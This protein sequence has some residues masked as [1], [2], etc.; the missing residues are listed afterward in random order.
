MHKP[1]KRIGLRGRI[2]TATSIALN[3]LFIFG[4]ITLLIILVK[5][6]YLQIFSTKSNKHEV[7]YKDNAAY[8]NYTTIYPL[9]Q[10][11]KNIVMLGNSLTAYASWAELLKRKDV[12]TRGINGDITAGFLA[13]LN[14]IINL[15]PKIVFI[16]GGV[17]DLNKGFSPEIILSNLSALIDTLQKNNIKAVLTT[18]TLLSE[19]HRAANILEMNQKIIRLNKQIAQLA[20]EKN[21]CLI[22]LNPYISNEN[23]LMPQYAVKDGIHF[24]GKVYE[25]WT[26]EVEKILKQENI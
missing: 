2:L 21:I 24:K 11:Q 26:L 22:D 7:D 10:H 13:R 8:E 16:E 12:A 15:K 18:V 6:N 3:I 14:H 25:L 9:Y 17:N 4:T 20:L 23:F 1:A 19:A 5:R